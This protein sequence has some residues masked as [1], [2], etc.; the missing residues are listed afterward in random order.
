MER[1]KRKKP[2]D[3]SNLRERKESRFMTKTNFEKLKENRLEKMD[4]A[5]IYQ[6]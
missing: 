2:I 5:Q 1:P 4:L 3:Y 6:K